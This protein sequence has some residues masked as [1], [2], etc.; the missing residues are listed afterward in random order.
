MAE[1]FN[2]D[3]AL[4][5]LFCRYPHLAKFIHSCKGGFEYLQAGKWIP[6]LFTD[7][8]SFAVVVV[9]YTTEKK[10]EIVLITFKGIY[11]AKVGNILEIAPLFVNGAINTS[12]VNTFK[13]EILKFNGSESGPS[14][15]DVNSTNHI[16][17][18]SSCLANSIE[19]ECHAYSHFVVGVTPAPAP[20]P[21]P[22]QKFVPIADF[23][24]LQAKALHFE[25]LFLESQ[26]KA[27]HFE[28]LFLESQ[29]K[30]KTLQKQR[31][32]AQTQ[33]F[34]SRDSLVEL[35]KSMSM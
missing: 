26:A 33:N 32:D 8:A 13:Y 17:G 25:K 22:E 4:T 5:K 10:D 18:I 23:F 20:E 12:M 9:Y 2:L 30:C 35:I 14:I 34:E 3:T 1:L 29:A 11:F 16:Y 24:A 6:V 21:A 27:L 15:I 28:K 31:N 19:G 7:I